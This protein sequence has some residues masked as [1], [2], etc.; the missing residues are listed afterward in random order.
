MGGGRRLRDDV[1]RRGSGEGLLK[2]AA[3]LSSGIEASGGA[4]ASTEEFCSREHRLGF[5]LVN[6]RNP[7]AGETVRLVPGMPLELADAEGVFGIVDSESA[8][9]LRSCL[10]AEWTM[11]GK[12]VAFSVTSGRGVAVVTGEQ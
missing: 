8:S 12:V 1:G 2:A 6:G 5:R 3:A 11:T 9:A 7:S 4:A 10:D